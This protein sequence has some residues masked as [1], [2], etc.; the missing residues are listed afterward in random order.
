MEWV[1]ETAHRITE[2]HKMSQR[3]TFSSVRTEKK[4]MTKPNIEQKERQKLGRWLSD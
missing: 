1:D 4:K 3:N 2:T